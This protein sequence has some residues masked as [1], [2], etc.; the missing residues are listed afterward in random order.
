LLT[1]YFYIFY[2]GGLMK[3]KSGIK[4]LII[5]IVVI[6]CLGGI[7]AYLVWG[8]GIFNKDEAVVEAVKTYTVASGNLTT[9]ISASGNLALAETE[10]AVV[11]IFYPNHAYATIGEVLVEV[12]DTV[13]KGQVLVTLDKKEWNDQIHT[14]QDTVTTKE[15]AIDQAQLDLKNAEQAVESAN[16]T[17]VTKETAVKSAEITVADAQDAVNNAITSIDFESY[18]A[19]LRVAQTRYD[20]IANTVPE[21]G[22]MSWDDWEIAMDAATEALTIA[23][24]NYDNALA[25]Y[26][27]E[28][29]TLKKTQLEIAQENL[30]AAEQAVI[31]AQANVPLKEMSLT[32]SQGKLEDAEKA[33]QT[34]KDDLAEAQTMSPEILAPIDGLITEVTVS[35][36]DE[37]LDGKVV[38]QVANEDKFKVELAVSEDDISDIKVDGT[39][40]VTV[41]ALSVTLPAT[42]TYIAPTAVISSGVVTYSVRV[43]IQEM[44]APQDSG[45]STSVP[46]STSSDNMTLPEGFSGQMPTLAD[47]NLKQGMTVTVNIVI[48]EAKDVLLVPYAAVKTEG[49]TKYVEV[50]KDD[51]TTEKRTVT[52]GITDDSNI[53]I[54]SG[55]TAGE[56]IVYSGTVAAVTTNTNPFGGGG[57][58][59]GGMIG[60][61]GPPGG[62]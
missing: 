10:D 12:G 41:D 17:I 40:Y 42:V 38:M 21:T 13:T 47:L 22:L 26:T 31:D 36:G 35:A 60:G 20:Y 32:I 16:N 25:G 33:L 44:T 6:L 15:R 14:L 2:K 62:G 18:V 61:G 8:V 48:A 46:S 39:A 5:A 4:K 23:Q 29:V 43:E 27:S 58:F 54:T 56:K 9:E 45:N 51:G 3:R 49:M 55:L 11:N 30:A 50:M 57:G 59:P 34:A 52:T 37:V 7:A 1:V 28:E 53:V 19:A 24:T